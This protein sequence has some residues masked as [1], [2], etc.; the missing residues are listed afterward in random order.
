MNVWRVILH[1]DVRDESGNKI[2]YP[3][4]KEEI[5]LKYYLDNN[6]VA[7]G[8]PID[9]EMSDTNNFEEYWKYSNNVYDSQDFKASVRAFGEYVKPED[10][11]W[12]KSRMSRML[13]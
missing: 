8:W 10:L 7:I 13:S 1:G 3:K 11:I 2:N 6:V 5:L 9:E 12:A 4:N